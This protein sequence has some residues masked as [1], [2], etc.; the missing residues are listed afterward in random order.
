VRSQYRTANSTNNKQQHMFRPTEV[1]AYRCL[2]V[3]FLPLV[4]QPSL[5]YSPLLSR[6]YLSLTRKPPLSYIWGRS[7]VRIHY[8]GTEF[9]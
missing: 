9:A 4:P 5:S 7:D 8:I 2:I 1:S 3:G 6:D